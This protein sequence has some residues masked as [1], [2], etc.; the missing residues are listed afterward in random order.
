MLN[1]VPEITIYFWIV[2]VFATTV[3]E[4]V[5]DFLNV[6]M[7]LGLTH[8][9]EIMAGLFI[10]ALAVQLTRKRYVPSIYWLVVV[11]ISVVG[12][13]ISD[14]LVD[15]YHIALATTSTVFAAALAVVF[16]AW[17]KSEKTLSVHLV[18]TTKREL[19]YWSAILFT[20]ALG[21]SA[22]DLIAEASHLGYPLSAL[23]F[24]TGIA[25]TFVVYR[26]F[27]IDGVLAFW[28]A[29]ILTRPLGASTGDLLS[30]PVSAGG[31]G[32]GTTLTSAAFLTVIVGMNVFMT[33]RLKATALR[34]RSG[35]RRDATLERLSA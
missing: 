24:A 31:L 4:T 15:K 17:W 9:S 18:R 32:W 14:T 34:E 25:L 23:L 12:T 13:L 10:V 8:T 22:G 11:L 3:G 28:I 27:K 21:T 5:A 30:Q 35:E 6:K 7:K 33:I 2:K 26:V 20:F 19:F 1:K 29:Y 16:F